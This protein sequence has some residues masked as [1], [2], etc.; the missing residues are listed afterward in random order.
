MPGKR[1]SFDVLQ[2]I[3]YNHQLG[4]SARELSEM[5]CISRK[6]IYNVINRAENENRLEPKCG[7]GPSK[8]ITK[9]A[10]RVIMRKI[11]Q[12]PQVS[13]RTLAR[14]L[15]EE[16]GIVVSHE[17]VRQTILQHKYF[18]RSARKKPLLS[19]ANVEK[20]L[21]FATMLISEPVDYRDDVIFCDETKMMLYYNDGPT[22]VWR[23][24]LTS[25]EKRNIIPTVKFGKLSVMIWGCISSRGVGDL[26]FIED[27]MDST[28][29]LQILKRHL[30]SSAT[31]FGFVTN[32]KPY[33]KFYQ[34]NDPKH[35]EHRVRMW[36][37]YNCGKVMDTPA[38]SPDLNPIENLWVHLKKKVA[39]RQPKNRTA[40]KTAIL[41]EWHDIPNNYDLVK[42]VQSM[43]KRLQCVIVAKGNHTKY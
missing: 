7:G 21:S 29:Y 16:C 18:S 9:R 28:Q 5:F 19:S 30:V 4:K 12:N 27:T 22:I 15:K 10:D 1:L 24:A 36:L 32:N 34:D 43:K 26:A 14:E 20:R 17:T 8:K 41:E 42:L 38:Q 13:T 31:K 39:K 35:K 33:F 6:T 11:H 40:L 25:L 37:L 3:Y 23:K 2:L